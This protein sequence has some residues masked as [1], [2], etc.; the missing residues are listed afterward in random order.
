MPIHLTSLR[1]RSFL[2]TSLGAGAS[3]LT[4]G[5]ALGDQTYDAT[6]HVAL[7]S[8]T[9]VDADATKVVRGSVMSA[10]LVNVIE[11]V[12][13]QTQKPTIAL[14]DGDCAFN[15]GLPA[16]YKTLAS[17]L[18][19]FPAADIPLH[20]TMG[21]HDD[22]VAFHKQFASHGKENAA[23]DGK[24]V[25]MVETKFANWFLIDTLQQVNHVTGEMGA[26]QIR[27]LRAALKANAGK[28][29]I[30]VGHHNPQFN[31]PDGGRVTG[32]QDSVALFDLLE[33]QPHVKAYVFG[34]THSYSVKQRPSGLHLINLPPIGYA[35]SETSP[36]GW[37]DASLS[38]TGM[39][40]T[41]RCID[42]GH[43]QH[44]ATETVAW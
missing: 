32:L 21:N 29:A 37:V 43:D 3:L 12:L 7:L 41:L 20:M 36:I 8:D 11:D 17:M 34:H 18:T 14:I 39:Q 33:S 2:Q 16:D 25:S 27:W 4:F 40:L 23:V 5:P 9:H 31:V 26:Q 24:H 13:D 6:E 28:P 10:N 35:F 15:V 1:R 42:N 38:A 44:L 19:A 22:R 30:V